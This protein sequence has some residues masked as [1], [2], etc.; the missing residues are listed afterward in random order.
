[1]IPPRTRRRPTDSVFLGG[2]GADLF[3]LGYPGFGVFK[4]LSLGGLGVW[5]LVDVVLI[6]AGFLGP[7]DGSLY[8]YS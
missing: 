1:M 6:G 5:T 8:Y 3:Y 4:M 2:F 7:A